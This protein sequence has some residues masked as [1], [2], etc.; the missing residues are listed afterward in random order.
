MKSILTKKKSTNLKKHNLKKSH[1]TKKSIL[2]LQ[3]N[4]AG[5]KFHLLHKDKSSIHATVVTNEA[6][7]LED[8]VALNKLRFSIDKIAMAI[9]MLDETNFIIDDAFR[10]KKEDDNGGDYD[11]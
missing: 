7:V 1:Y 8:K 3:R 5:E 10:L 2:Q 6:V 4:E 11:Y 9:Q